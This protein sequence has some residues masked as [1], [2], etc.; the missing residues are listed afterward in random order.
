MSAGT[1]ACVGHVLSSPAS[2]L[3]QFQL[4]D[5]IRLEFLAFSE[6]YLSTQMEKN[7]TRLAL[8]NDLEPE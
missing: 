4:S 3:F 2:R 7:Y 8:L 6:N 1:L 5:S